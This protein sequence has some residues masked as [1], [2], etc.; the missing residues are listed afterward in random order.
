MSF[1]LLLTAYVKDKVI[2]LLRKS[3]LTNDY[4][5]DQILSI[6]YP[7]CL[8]IVLYTT[9]PDAMK[10]Y[11]TENGF[12]TETI[13]NPNTITMVYRDI[14]S[15]RVTTDQGIYSAEKTRSYKIAS[16]N[17]S[18]VVKQMLKNG[19]K[20]PQMYTDLEILAAYK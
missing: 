16:I 7:K 5:T 8:Y 15:I 17:F 11:L 12:T 4:Y 20:L 3:V 19:Y 13:N 6:L 9:R 2:D 14:V 1:H 10:H 18:H